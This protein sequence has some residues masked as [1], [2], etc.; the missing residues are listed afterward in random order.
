MHQQQLV[1]IGSHSAG[2]AFGHIEQLEHRTHG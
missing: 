1:Q 2:P